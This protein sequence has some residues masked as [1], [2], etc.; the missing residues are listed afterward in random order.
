M[1][2]ILAIAES[3]KGVGETAGGVSKYGKWLDQQVGT[4]LYYNL[5]WCGAF[6]MWAIAQG[7]PEWS[8]AAGGI[9]RGFAEV[10]VWY[11]WMH[12]HGRISHTPLPRRLVWYDWAG[13]PKGANHIGMVASVS[14]GTMTVWEGNHNNRVELV[15][16]STT[17]QVMGYGEWWSFIQHPA[18]LD[19]D[20]WMG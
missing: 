14:G 7:G 6:Q 11:D 12:V 3:Q 16:R 1:T 5:D 17:S 20:C 15:T 8:A 18:P 19:A 13:T 4:H 9:Q 2:D 10:Q